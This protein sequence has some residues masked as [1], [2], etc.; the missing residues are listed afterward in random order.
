MTSTDATVLLVFVPLLAACLAVLAP[1]RARSPIA[2]ATLLALPLLLWVVTS[3]VLADG[4]LHV[5]LAG[6]AAPLGIQLR[7]DGLALL[8]LWLVALAGGAAGLYALASHPPASA[9][10]G[11]FWPL[12]LL[13]LAGL[14]GLFL[15]AD[16][17]NVYVAIELVTLSAIALIA[18][19]G[20]AGALRAA[21]RYLL[22]A[23]LASL[24]YLLGVALLYA[25]HGSLDLYALARSVAEPQASHA[26]L[27]ALSLISIALL[28]KAAVFPLHVWLPAAH[29]QAPGAVSAVLSA[30]VVKTAVVLL[31]RLWFWTAA[32]LDRDAVWLLFGLLG[33]AA[34]L[35]G[36]LAALVQ[37]QIKRVVAYSTVA[38]LGYLMLVFPLIG[39]T[40]GAPSAWYGAGCQLASH[41]LAK[42]A[43]F[44]A[45]AG[46]VHGLGS[47]RI[48][49]LAGAGK[50]FPVCLFAFGLAGVSLM[51]L[52]P[53]GGFLAKW[54]LLEAAWAQ[55]GWGWIA[56]LLV[57]SLLAAGY[58]FR[59]LAAAFVASPA[60]GAAV[61]PVSSAMSLPALAL[62]LL[63]LVMGFVAA[64]LFQLLAVAAPDIAGVAPA[65]GG[66]R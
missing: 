3:A 21:M 56:V 64:P 6:H 32:G 38:Q 48:D 5:A 16:L 8:M 41:G 53:S 55:R 58:V 61:R 57:G 20:Q 7:A 50:A 52:P 28:L 39:H 29:A 17:F 9:H 62:A 31:Y 25:E 22:L 30:L 37:A 36:S 65:H 40:G 27:T 34:V 54:L 43:M 35:F 26:T 46:L 4:V 10:G 15:S 60:G 51:G 14:N 47:G 11:R 59:V 63:S 2:A 42:A 23:M 44:L 49:R 13:M 24:A 12:W 18:A 19:D 1:P 33:A 45:A 66:S